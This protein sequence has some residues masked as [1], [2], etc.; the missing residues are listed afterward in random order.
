MPQPRLYVD[1][2]ARVRAHRA[3]KRRAEL[4]PHVHCRQIGCCTLYQSDWQTVYPL[5]PHHAAVITDPPYDAGYDYTKARRRPSQWD[6]NFVGMDAPFDP[7]P[8]LQFPEVVLFGADRYADHL[9]AGRWWCWHKTPGRQPA[10]FAPC[11]W[12][13]LS[14]PGPPRYYPYLWCGGMR[15]GEENYVRLPQKLHPAQKPVQLLTDL[16][17]QTAAPMVIDPY[18]G[19]GSTLVACV[20]LGRPC[21]GIEVDEHYFAV[22]CER[23]QQEVAALA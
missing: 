10:D 21:I 7:T 14:T 9:A 19:S 5:L 17:L 2:A 8:W 11:E 22:A 20:R 3:R 1:A 12:L 13:W 6:Q 16:V 4:A 23:L 18:M 15:Q